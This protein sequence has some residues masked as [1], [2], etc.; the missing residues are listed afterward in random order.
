[1]VL[2]VLFLGIFP[3]FSED[4][5]G[6]VIDRGLDV[7]YSYYKDHWV[8]GL[9]DGSC[10]RLLPLKEKRKQTWG[11][12]WSGEN[13][14]EWSLSDEF[15]FDPN[16]WNGRYQVCIYEAKDSVEKG[17]NFIL[18]NEQNG[19][20]VFARFALNDSGFIPRIAYAKEILDRA[21]S[22]SSCALKKYRFDEDIL[23]L[24]DC[25]TWQLVLQTENSRSFSQW[26]N[27]EKIDQPDPEFITKIKDWKPFDEIV[28]HRFC[29]DY[30]KLFEKYRVPKIDRE[31]CLIENKTLQKFAYA[32]ELSFK[33]FLEAFETYA[34]K[35]RERGYE[36]GFLRGQ[37]TG[38][39]HGRQ[40]GRKEMEK[41]YEEGFLTGQKAGYSEGYRRGVEELRLQY[42]EEGAAN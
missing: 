39:S 6:E 12:W 13:P 42:Q 22:S 24:K 34:R 30:E 41:N 36:N 37:N 17:Y 20:K 29:F 38:Y 33:A 2:W 26:W 21:E 3:L 23:I 15:F 19:Q 11:E 8:I 28:K 9:E 14:K 31:V 10:W 5:L 27:G 25:S 16:S 18:A 32:K 1:M 35:E 4:F 40:V 7:R